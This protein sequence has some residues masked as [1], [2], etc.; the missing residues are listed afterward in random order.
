MTTCSSRSFHFELYPKICR[1]RDLPAL[2]WMG[3]F[4]NQREIIRDTYTRQQR[5]EALMLLGMSNEY[6]LAQAWLDFTKRGSWQRPRVWALRVFPPLQGLGIGTWML[7]AAEAV[8][9]SRG[10]RELELGVEK[11]NIDAQRL[12]DRLGYRATSTEVAIDPNHAD[13]GAIIDQ[14]L[15]AKSL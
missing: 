3:L 6:P 15:L 12:Y 5:G 13:G 10:A 1:D 2:E 7:R 8:A 9:K 4:S 14:Y 11:T